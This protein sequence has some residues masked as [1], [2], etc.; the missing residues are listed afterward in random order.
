MNHHSPIA[1][2]GLPCIAVPAVFAVIALAFDW[3]I[4]AVISLFADTFCCLVLS[5]SGKKNTQEFKV[6]HLPGRR[7]GPANRRGR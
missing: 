4:S 2:E 6:H 5:E 7:K 3:R 1:A